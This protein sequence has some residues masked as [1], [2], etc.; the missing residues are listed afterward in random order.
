MGAGSVGGGFHL[1]ADTD[2]LS[3]GLHMDEDYVGVARADV[4]HGRCSYLLGYAT[5]LD[6]RGLV[7]PGPVDSHAFIPQ[8]QGAA[9]E[10]GPSEI[11]RPVLANEL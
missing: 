11:L 4:D 5:T 8:P 6:R 2:E 7:H 1:L 3:S 10:I 9:V